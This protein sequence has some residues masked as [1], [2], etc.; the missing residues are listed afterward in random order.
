L[1]SNNVVLTIERFFLDL[2][3]MI[4][5]GGLLIFSIQMTDAT[6]SNLICSKLNSQTIIS[7]LIVYLTTSYI[8]GYVLITIGNF[9][10]NIIKKEDLNSL[11]NYQV[12]KDFVLTK[13]KA[14]HFDE[15][16][17]HKELR[18]LA[19]SLVPDDKQIVHRFM[20][21]SL[22]MMGVA[23]A[24]FMSLFYWICINLCLI[25]QTKSLLP[26]NWSQGQIV[27]LVLIAASACVIQAKEFYR[28]SQSVPFSQAVAK[29]IIQSSLLMEG[30]DQ[31]TEN[32]KNIIYNNKPII[33]LAGGFKSK[34][35]QKVK[36]VCKSCIFID[37]SKHHLKE[38]KEY[39]TWD[40]YTIK[41]SD[42][43][44]AY[45]ENSNPGGYSL[46][47][48]VGYAKALGKTIILINEKTLPSGIFN[49][50]MKMVESC[51]D[52]VYRN[53]D[54]GIIYLK[55]INNHIRTLK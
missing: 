42:I 18:N 54:E 50:Y 45:L 43:I 49:P 55:Q 21:I 20:F 9:F 10:S 51:C 19:M 31:I 12:F 33:Y 13:T 26:L 22:L 39:T 5:P 44:F 41:K 30:D 35:Q 7:P 6:L 32:T 14:Q 8:L 46:A 25:I 34:W 1:E 40:L 11:W 3:G 24:L 17:I 37:P 27:T 2:I 47:L 36:N 52:V 48:E 15:T 16:K 53:L 23:T 4:I 38:A 29:Y 28:R